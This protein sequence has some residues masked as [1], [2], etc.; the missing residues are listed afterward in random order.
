MKQF[1]FLFLSAT[2]VSGCHFKKGSGHIISQ[3]RDTPSFKGVAAGGAF[4]V[5]IKIGN[6]TEVIVESDDNLIA[7]IDTKVE[8]DVLKIS[9][10][11]NNINSGHFKVYVTTPEINFIKG[12]GASTIKA[13]DQLSNANKISF[14]ASG[15]STII[16]AVDAPSIDAEASGSSKIELNGRTRQYNAAAEGSSDIKSSQLQSE[17]TIIKASGAS[18]VHSHASLSIAV[19]AS[20][21]SN[22]YYRGGAV[23]KSDVS[24]ASNVK[25]EN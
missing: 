19:E 2:L 20:G 15:A 22:V 23:L 4:E 17:N 3:K 6:L 24:G 1:L 16:A 11:T 5:E 18:S 7:F 9:T 14:E 13:V 10:R 21:A 8:N 12:S 25:Q